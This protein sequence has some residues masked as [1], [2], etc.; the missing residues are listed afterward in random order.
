MGEKSPTLQKVLTMLEQ[1]L[2][3]IHNYFVHDVYTGEFTISGGVLQGDYIIDGQYYKING[4]IFNNGLHLKGT[5]QGAEVLTDETFE[6]E[7]WGL[8][9]P[10]AVISL[11][12]DV[13][14]WMDT[15]GA[16]VNT[17]YQS[18]SFGGY[19]Y[20]KASGSGSSGNKPST[21]SWQDVFATRLNAYRKINNDFVL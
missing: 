2:D 17:P 20:S 14:S 13:A 1:I 10:P 12:S 15:Y 5:G 11:A 21:A 19:S 3:Y 9:V 6:G 18:E 4:S 16:V 8:A 7:V